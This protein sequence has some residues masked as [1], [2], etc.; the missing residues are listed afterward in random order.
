MGSQ[1]DGE[2]LKSEI[3]DPET[4]RSNKANSLAP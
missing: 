2:M 3:T 1:N 4:E